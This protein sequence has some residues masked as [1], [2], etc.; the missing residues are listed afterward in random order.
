MDER[1]ETYHEYSIDAEDQPQS[2]GDSSTDDRGLPEPLDEGYSPPEKYSPAQRYG[3][4]A[5]EEIQGE[6]LDQRLAQ[7]LPDDPTAP[8]GEQVGGPQVGDERAG[9]LVADGDDVTAI[10]VGIDGAGAGAEEAA[11]HVIDGT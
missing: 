7:E 2:G 4:T 9:R 8:S 5:A 3:N 11:V 6:S 10:D 1:R